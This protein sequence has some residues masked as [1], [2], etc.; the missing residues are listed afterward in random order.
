MLEIGAAGAAPP[1][2]PHP[3]A[4]WSP[5][6]ALA[7]TFVAMLAFSWGTW[8]DVMTDFG[9]EL[10]SSWQLAEG[11]ALGRDVFLPQTGTLTPYFNALA[12]GI[13]GTSLR[14]LVLVNLCILVGITALLHRLLRELGDRL[15]ATLATGFFLVVFAFGQYVGI[16][17]YNYVTPYSHGA[18]HGMALSL[19]A[20]AF[21]WRHSTTGALRELVLSSVAAGLVL[22]TKPEFFVA[23]AGAIGC[24]GALRVRDAPDA[25]TRMRWALALTLP[26]AGPALASVALLTARDGLSP[27]LEST[28]APWLA[29]LTP[30]AR[31]PFYLAGFGLDDP[32][33]N[34]ARAGT[35]LLAGGAVFAAAA[36][37][38]VLAHRAG[39]TRV[40]A[41][42]AA[43]AAAAGAW[44]LVPLPDWYGV[45]RPLPA[46]AAAAAAA[47]L[48]SAWR[49]PRPTP[50]ARLLR[51]GLW[52]LAVLL[53]LKMALAARLHHYGFVLAMPAALLSI[54]WLI[55]DA[56]GLLRDRRGSGIVFRAVA[57]AIVAV[58]A[59]AYVRYASAAFATKPITVGS[60]SDSFQADPRGFYVNAMVA[61]LSK[62]ARPGA[63]LGVLPEG[64][65][66][67]YLARMESPA[68]L[69]TYLPDGIALMGEQALLAPYRE[70]PPDF[71]VIASR[72]AT[73]H[74]ATTF[75]I[76]YARET[77]R[78]IVAN[79]EPIETVG[80]SPLGRTRMYGLMLLKRVDRSR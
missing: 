7:V 73:E 10:Y 58:V 22:L 3:L 36:V 55:G 43:P 17:N 74:G 48:A 6:A 19:L 4:R 34:V 79:Y 52:V 62:L 32:L 77:L 47:A 66:I 67:N 75:G 68:R 50:P 42:V 80:A 78:W 13:L 60:G 9:T 12:F 26:A 29:M 20:I 23:S 49:G 51:A 5:P 28:F 35:W 56:P 61:R 57:A 40:A 69:S 63:T 53:L 71:I 54:A 37:V 30:F 76:D 14:T 65:M 46:V 15:S 31:T 1:V 24:M 38:D 27:A 41:W 72:D 2:R 16:G 64:I 59:S 39:V 21:L 18:T 70:K 45:A 8:P 25:R 44:L 11:K 33:A